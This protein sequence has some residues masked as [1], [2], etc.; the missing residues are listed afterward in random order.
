MRRILV[1]FSLSLLFLILDNTLMP[2]ISIKGYYPSLLFLFSIC[3]SIINGPEDGLFVG[4]F[5]GAIQDLYFFN[6]FGINIFTNMLMCVA[7]GFIGKS[8]FKEKPIIPVLSCFFLSAIKGV[9]VF[10]ILY[11]VK[12]Q[13]HIQDVLYNSIYG[14][15]VSIIIYR[16]IYKLCKKDYMIKQW[17]F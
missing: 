8:I 17:K 10:C 9:L 3:F 1:A 13:T 12:Q 16:K 15:V 5:T 4:I 7:A 11:L 2:F 6:G 14:M